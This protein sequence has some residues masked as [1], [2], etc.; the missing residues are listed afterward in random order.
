MRGVV[1]LVLLFTVAVVAA[2]TLG[3]N[4]GIVSLYWSG[5]RTDLSLNLF[6]LLLVAFCLLITLAVQALLALTTL[7][8]RASEWRGQRKERAAQAALREALAEFFSARYGRAQKA[9]G[10]ALDIQADVPSMRGDAEFGVLARLLSAASAHRLQDRPRRDAE[11]AQALPQ[12]GRAVGRADDGA[13]LLA[14]EWALDDRDAERAQALLDEL[15]AGVARRTQALRLKLQA[16]RLLRD[17]SSALHMARMLANHGAFSEVAAKGLLRSLAFDALDDTHDMQQLQRAWDAFDTAD[18]RDP[19][20]AARAATR[21]GALEG[22][23]VGRGW[24]RPFWERLSDVGR[25]EREHLALAF[26]AV[27]EGLQTHQ[28]DW[29]P[30]LDAAASAFGHEPA[31]GAAVAMGFAECRLWGK[32]RRLLEG[33][34][35]AATLPAKLRRRAWRK[36]AELAREEGDI[37]RERACQRAAAA[38]D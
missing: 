11:L 24:L 35:G 22:A 14:A 16:A 21:A 26:I 19:F 17:G 30:R 12:A 27:L 15:P 31:V 38:I 36:L 33:S 3:S 25:D 5:W 34:A 9:A 29:L 23:A 18:R 4:D 37:E 20:V 28:H 2:T 6:V 13:R 10:R 32:A 7:P 1:W 8:Q